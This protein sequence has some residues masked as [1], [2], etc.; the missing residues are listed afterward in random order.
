MNPLE[1]KVQHF[2]KYAY[3]LSCQALDEKIETTGRQSGLQHLC[4]KA[5][6][7]ISQHFK[8]FL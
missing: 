2:A 5:N 6:E 8:L 4:Q 1:E 3:L 7:H